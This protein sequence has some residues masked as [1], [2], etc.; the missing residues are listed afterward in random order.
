MSDTCALKDKEREVMVDFIDIYRKHV[1]LWKVK[2][3]EY[4]NRNLRNKGIDELHGKLQELDPHC[5]RDDVMKKIN[6]LRSS[7]R[8]ELRK[9]ESSKKSGNATDDIYTP[10]LWY[11]EDMMFICDQEMP[12]E[13]TSNMESVNEESVAEPPADDEIPSCSNAPVVKRSRGN[14]TKADHFLNLVAR[15]LEERSERHDTP[16]ETFGKYVGQALD[17]LDKKTAGCARK[18]INDVLFEAENGNLSAYSKIVTNTYHSHESFA[19]PVPQSSSSFH[20]SDNSNSDS[21]MSHY[22]ANFQPL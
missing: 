20:V 8:R 19:T 16:N 11:F 22:F 21:N 18:L 10:T 13:S 2:S 17:S 14:T 3:K 15:N 1:A 7:F 12:R 5:T 9:H 4:S 6:S